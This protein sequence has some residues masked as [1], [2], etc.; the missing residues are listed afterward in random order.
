MNNIVRLLLAFT[1]AGTCLIA[2][3]VAPQPLET[4]LVE[5]NNIQWIGQGIGGMQGELLNLSFLLEETLTP[6]FNADAAYAPQVVPGSVNIHGSGFLGGIGPTVDQLNCHDCTAGVNFGM[7]FMPFFTST[8]DE[9]DLHG[10]GPNL[11]S[12]NFGNFYLYPGD[13]AE[14]SGLIYFWSCRSFD[15]ITG[16]GRSDPAFP[17]TNAV[18]M[19]KS[20]TVKVTRVPEY[21]DPLTY[22]GLDLAGLLAAG[23]FLRR[24]L[25]A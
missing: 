8:G 6:W 24:R 9:I 23:W 13:Y 11:A 14:P 17:L 25:A 7:D 22:L 5:F 10:F 21:G 18:I 2:D 20:G 12:T 4:V 19:P 16:F 3:T 15:C 1:L